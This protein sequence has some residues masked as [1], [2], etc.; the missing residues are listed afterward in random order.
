MEE[1]CEREPCRKVSIMPGLCAVHWVGQRRN[2]WVTGQLAACAHTCSRCNQ[3]F[4][5]ICTAPLK[6]L[7]LLL[8]S[9][10]HGRQGKH[11]CCSIPLKMDI[12]RAQTKEKTPRPSANKQTQCTE[13]VRAL[14]SAAAHCWVSTFPFCIVC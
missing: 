14:E 8:I 9:Q 13:Q 3:C 10:G 5:G 11:N 6:M 12:S 2:A 1:L 7:I 4:I